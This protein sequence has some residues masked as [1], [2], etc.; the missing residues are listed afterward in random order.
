MH[1]LWLGTHIGALSGFPGGAQTPPR[2]FWSSGDTGVWPCGTD[3]A[4][5]L[6]CLPD[7]WELDGRTHAFT[8]PWLVGRL[9][10][11]GLSRL[12]RIAHRTT[13]PLHT[14]L[15]GWTR[16]ALLWT[17]RHDDTA[18]P[19]GEQVL[20]RWDQ[21]DAPPLPTKEQ[22]LHPSIS[23]ATA[24]R[25]AVSV[26]LGR[27]H[28]MEAPH[29]ADDSWR[30]SPVGLFVAFRAPAQGHARLAWQ[31]RLEEDVA[32]ADA[33]TLPRTHAGAAAHHAT[34]P[35]GQDGENVRDAVPPPHPPRP[36]LA[37][38][39]TRPPYVQGP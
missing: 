34:S 33:W 6:P 3:T 11:A 30:Y 14:P 15:L 38:L 35:P 17:G 22:G 31:R 4:T 37:L 7:G 5:V 12:E 18:W 19:T 32:L 27:L 16:D 39:P 28:G 26:L 25:T 36:L 23:L 1:R 8:L 10:E 21:P 13:C 20:S 29:G 24:Q 2:A 9:A